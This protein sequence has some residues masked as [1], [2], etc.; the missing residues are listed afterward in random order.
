LECSA[1]VR[2]ARMVRTN[3]GLISC[4]NCGIR[5]RCPCRFRYSRLGEGTIFSMTSRVRQNSRRS[6]SAPVIAA[7]PRSW[8]S[9]QQAFLPDREQDH[10]CGAPGRYGERCASSE[11]KA[12]VNAHA[13]LHVHMPMVH[14]LTASLSH[15]TGHSNVVT[16]S[17]SPESSGSARCVLIR[18]DHL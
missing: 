4:E 9:G 13:Q 5:S 12:F 15:P 3:S 2:A 6:T 10:K 18:G 17:S 1:S 16:L 11:R 14:R 8:C 7:P